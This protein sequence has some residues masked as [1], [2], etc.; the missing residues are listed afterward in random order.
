[1]LVV[2]G[3]TLEIRQPTLQRYSLSL[4]GTLIAAVEDRGLI[5]TTI[6]IFDDSLIHKE[7]Y[8]PPGFHP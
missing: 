6:I 4:G 8:C 2:F 1:V 5:E 7:S 3:L